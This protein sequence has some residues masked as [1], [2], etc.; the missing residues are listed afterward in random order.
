V[1][2]QHEA[3]SLIFFPWNR[4]A[5]KFAG[6]RAYVHGLELGDGS[7]VVITAAEE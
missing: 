1:E 3:A 7:P 4:E 5:R 2:G 6:E